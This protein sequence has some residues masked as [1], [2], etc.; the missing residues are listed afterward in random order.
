MKWRDY[1]HHNVNCSMLGIWKVS[2]IRFINGSISTCHHPVP[3]FIISLL[4]LV[5]TNLHDI[6]LGLSS[7]AI[8]SLCMFPQK[9]SFIVS[10][11]A[12]LCKFVTLLFEVSYWMKVL[13]QSLICQISPCHSKPL[14][15]CHC[16]FHPTFFPSIN[17]L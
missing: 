9:N 10:P 2:I 8:P 3:V 1:P 15:A 17:F 16:R 13:V 14:L 7:S 5:I 6:G 11:P 12:M 4:Q